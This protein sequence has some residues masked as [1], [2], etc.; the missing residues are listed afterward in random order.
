MLV[1]ELRKVGFKVKISSNLGDSQVEVNFNMTVDTFVFD[2]SE[3]RYRDHETK[4][5]CPSYYTI[6]EFDPSTGAL[7]V[8]ENAYHEPLF[9]STIV[10]AKWKLKSI[11]ASSDEE[12]SVSTQAA[13]LSSLHIASAV[14]THEKIASNMVS[15]G[16]SVAPDAAN[17]S[18][19]VSSRA[20][21][22]PVRADTSSQLTVMANTK[23]GA[24]TASAAAALST[25]CI[26]SPPPARQ[27]GA[28]HTS[29]AFMGSSTQQ[30]QHLHRKSSTT[31]V[32]THE[33]I[34]NNMVSAGNSVAPDAANHSRLVSSRASKSPVRADTS[35]PLTVMANTKTGA[36]TAS[37]AAALSALRNTSTPTF[38]S[39]NA[40]EE[41]SFATGDGS[42]HR[43]S[44]SSS[45]SQ[46]HRTRPQKP[47][48]FLLSS[49]QLPDD[50]DSYMGG[51]SGNTDD[52]EDDHSPILRMT[53]VLPHIDEDECRGKL[54]AIL[55]TRLAAAETLEAVTGN[56]FH[57]VKH[58]RTDTNNYD[59]FA[60]MRSV[61][62][63]YMAQKYGK[64]NA[65]NKG[66]V[67][68]KS[69]SGKGILK[70][71]KVNMTRYEYGVNHKI[72]RNVDTQV[73]AMATEM[74]SYWKS[75]GEL[76][77]DD[78]E[79]VNV[80]QYN[81]ETISMIAKAFGN[82]VTPGGC[83]FE[84]RI[85]GQDN[86]SMHLMIEVLRQHKGQSSV[87]LPKTMQDAKDKIAKRQ[88]AVADAIVA[89]TSAASIETAA[90]IAAATA[91]VAAAKVV[92]TATTEMD[93]IVEAEAEE[94]GATEL[95]AD[96]GA[97]SE[98]ELDDGDLTAMLSD[99]ISDVDAPFDGNKDIDFGDSEDEGVSQAGGYDLDD[100]YDHDDNNDMWGDNGDEGGGDQNDD[101]TTIS[102]QSVQPKEFTAV[103]SAVPNSPMSPVSQLSNEDHEERQE[104]Q[105][106][107]QQ[108]EQKQ[109][110]SQQSRG[111]GMEFWEQTVGPTNVTIDGQDHNNLDFS[112]GVTILVNS[113]TKRNT[114][115]N[116]AKLEI[117]FLRDVTN[118][119]KRAR[120]FEHLV[121]KGQWLCEKA[122]VD[123]SMENPLAQFQAQ[124]L[125]AHTSIETVFVHGIVCPFITN[126]ISG[127]V[128]EDG[129]GEFIYGHN[130]D[131]KFT[132]LDSPYKDDD[133][134]QT[135]LLITGQSFSFMH[136]RSFQ[137]KQRNLTNN[138][139]SQHGN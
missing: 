58:A 134:I 60:L 32:V 108:Q 119:P 133:N 76:N 9:P 45:V 56:Y 126:T 130:A 39:S 81:K 132:W 95:V 21:K 94:T 131:F 71:D 75:L 85:G 20:S 128:M 114:T 19:L 67:I 22:S 86:E 79:A 43:A 100:I 68:I 90:A 101:A 122:G 38:Q 2:S 72:Q 14:V 97:E 37:A 50:N 89:A 11:Q 104:E 62:E 112:W 42:N 99:D 121:M 91:T 103:A 23:T 127:E 120:L 24:A 4:D 36:A 129:G 57:S 93:I 78:D 52:E 111:T 27:D 31:V 115:S 92:A 33:K 110:D 46:Q 5:L 69:K 135:E 116:A 25:L 16:N 13:S 74:T 28:Q 35:S 49:Q 117:M 53:K 34:A 44:A 55:A 125:I 30:Q 137:D 66:K 118:S 7:S 124:K 87:K 8:N 18:R 82:V 136:T 102:F 84:E 54:V 40:R 96:S 29:S 6:K 63:Q 59:I 98:G 1:Y 107:E 113:V 17:H 3:K 65:H 51:N 73:R 88:K 83:N 109:S 123:I 80:P 15:A 138:R 10:A 41:E 70:S 12:S 64:A 105:H 47:S 139:S 77:T 48:C 106:F 26:V 61:G